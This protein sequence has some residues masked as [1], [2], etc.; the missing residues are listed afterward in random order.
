ME[1]AR[2]LRFA[3]ISGLILFSGP[4]LA[5][6][7]GCP[8]SE[9]SA[10]AMKGLQKAVKREQVD[11]LDLATLYYCTYRDSARVVVDTV[12]VPQSDGSESASTLSCSGSPDHARDWFCRVDRY[13]AIRVASGP[14]QPEARVEVGERASVES[15]R[16]YATRAFALL[17]EPGRI[18]SCQHMAGSGQTT[19]SLRAMLARRYGPYR[20]VISREGFALMRLDIQVRIRS[21]SEFNPRAQIQCWEENVIEE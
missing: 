21:A 3:A 6:I 10:A 7:S 11:P 18:E 17:N 20:L 2:I 14:G 1:A 12:A 13:R 19:E 4:S 8:R 15:T 16:E 5:D 9:I